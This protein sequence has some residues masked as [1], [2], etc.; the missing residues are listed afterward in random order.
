MALVFVLFYTLNLLLVVVLFMLTGQVGVMLQQ[1]RTMQVVQ[2]HR[3]MQVVQ[4]DGTPVQVMHQQR[5]IQQTAPHPQQQQIQ[6]QQGPPWRQAIVSSG[7]A[8]FKELRG[9]VVSYGR[10]V[11]SCLCV[12]LYLHFLISLCGIVF[13]SAQEQ[14]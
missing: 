2:Q 3:S 4:Q 9:T 7:N 13:N 10:C 14:F 6:I 8:F 1:Q 11:C 5:V 12:E